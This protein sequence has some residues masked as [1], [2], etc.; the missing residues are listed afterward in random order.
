MKFQV[1]DIIPA[2]REAAPTTL[3]EAEDPYGN[4]PESAHANTRSENAYVH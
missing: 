2:V 4:R 1:L 3:W